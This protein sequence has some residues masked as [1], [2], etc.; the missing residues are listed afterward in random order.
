MLGPVGV[1]AITAIGGATAGFGIGHGPGLRANG[2]EHRV[3]AHGAGTLLGVVRLQQQTSL[4]CPEPVERA[5]DVLEVQNAVL[6]CSLG[7]QRVGHRLDRKHNSVALS[8]SP[9]SL[10]KRVGHELDNSPKCSACP[11]AERVLSAE[12]ALQRDGYTNL[13]KVQQVTNLIA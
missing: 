13:Q 3:G 11:T 10:S 5:D 8:R 2:P 6:A 1:V 9:T 12:H 4:V 7:V